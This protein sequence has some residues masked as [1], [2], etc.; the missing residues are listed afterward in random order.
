MNPS[1]C[2]QESF[3]SI[4]KSLGLISKSTAWWPGRKSLCTGR[5]MKLKGL[6]HHVNPLVKGI[7]KQ[8]FSIVLELSCSESNAK[9][10]PF[11]A[12]Y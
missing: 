3:T 11:I 8:I 6:F 2:L 9:N 1:F 7:T 10:G 5:D 4:T 12:P